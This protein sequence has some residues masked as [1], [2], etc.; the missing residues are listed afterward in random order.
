MG[1][2]L[3]SDRSP[4]L[5]ESDAGEASRQEPDAKRQKTLCHTAA[6]GLLSLSSSTTTH[7][8]VRGGVTTSLLQLNPTIIE[9]CSSCVST[10]SHASPQAPKKKFLDRRRSF[11]Q[12][13]VSSSTPKLPAAKNALTMP[14]LPRAIQRRKIPLP[15]G[16][17]L[18]MSP[19]LA[20]HLELLTKPINLSLR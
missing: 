15:Q 11:R 17:P 6:L 4:A 18:M 16:K 19:K 14:R 1:K 8:T 13:S 3:S 5:I 2:R 7:T 9:D 20:E 12:S 10:S